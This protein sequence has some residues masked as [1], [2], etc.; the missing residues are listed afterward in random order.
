MIMLSFGG[1]VK[2]IM[3]AR[4]FKIRIIWIILAVIV[5]AAAG[6]GYYFW[7]QQQAKTASSSSVSR[8]ATTQARRGSITLSASGTGT[9]VAAQQVNMGFSASGT[10]A[11]VHVKAGDLVKSGDVLAELG[12]TENLQAAVHS[13]QVDLATAQ[14]ALDTLKQ[15][16][17]SALGT[18]Q[19]NLVHAQATATAAANGIVNKSMMR[20]DDATTLAYYN[21]YVKAQ[22]NLDTLGKPSDT[23]SSDYLFVYLPAQKS[24]DAAYSTW[25]Y[26]NNYTSY[27]I[28][29]SQ[30]QATIASA[31]VSQDQAIV[32]TLTPNNGLDP[33]QFS[34]A[35]NK[36]DVA[37]IALTTAQ[38]N[39]AGAV[40]KAP[41]AGSV[42]S[43]AGIVGDKVGTGTFI[44]LADLYHPYVQF[45][46]DEVDMG[47]V[48]LGDMVNVIF[49]ALP[50]QTFTG[51]VTV[52][53]PQLVTSGN[54]QALQG[55]ARL[56]TT[57]DSPLP[58]GIGASV[59]VIGGQANN[60]V[61]IPLT[62][63][64]DLGDGTYGVF[65][66]DNSGKLTFRTVTIG[67]QDLTNVEI[68]SGLQAGE[69]VSTGS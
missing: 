61:L 13:A 41:F 66:R 15:G 33:Y 55:L 46:V 44:V 14:Q 69:T 34:M 30:A 38:K 57:L 10:V 12:D 17:A 42:V 7:S 53:Q 39:L 58:L 35:Q 60:A 63:L 23:N 4:L 67:L 28:G 9:L 1:I 37:Q 43:V 65:V 47:K 18:A 59:D 56:D 50:K 54:A 40:L 48:A 6:G 11:A 26:C 8:L 21:A 68:T 2:S 27:E 16:A 45:D 3:N 64:R 51:K 49:D 19:L 36:V 25:K 5:I 52:I 32:A 24:R 29:N 20:C 22:K 62:A 31:T